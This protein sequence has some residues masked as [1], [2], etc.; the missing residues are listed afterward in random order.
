MRSRGRT[1]ESRK[2]SATLSS[3]AEESH[4]LLGPRAT[5]CGGRRAPRAGPAHANEE[6]SDENNDVR[7]YTKHA[8]RSERRV[9]GVGSYIPWQRPHAQAGGRRQR[10]HAPRCG[11]QRT[12]RSGRARWRVR[13]RA[14]A[15]RV[16]AATHST[17]AS[18]QGGQAQACGDDAATR[19]RAAQLAEA[20]LKN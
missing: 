8:D 15:G 3:R 18:A 2:D 16:A 14:R 9:E 10:P 19:W 5:V 17:D 12:N 4:M 6:W 11:H 1:S 13:R 20:G 7:D